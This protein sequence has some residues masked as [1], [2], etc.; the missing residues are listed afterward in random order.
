M[1]IT[2]ANCEKVV[3]AETLQKARALLFENKVIS[4]TNVEVNEHIGSLYEGVIKVG[5]KTYTLCFAIAING[6]IALDDCFCSFHTGSICKHYLAI[7]L[8]M[9]YR[10]NI[11]I[12]KRVFNPVRVILASSDSSPECVD[13]TVDSVFNRYI[14][15]NK[16][17]KWYMSCAIEGLVFAF[18]CAEAQEKSFLERTALYAVAFSKV[19]RLFSLSAEKHSRILISHAKTL[20]KLV[21]SYL[22]SKLP[23]TSL[24]DTKTA[25]FKFYETSKTIRNWMVKYNVLGILT[26]F[27]HTPSLRIFLERNFKKKI[28]NQKNVDKK[29]DLRVLY[30]MVLRAYS[31]KLASSYI[32]KNLDDASFR[33]MAIDLN[34]ANGEF[35]EAK[36]LAKEGL[37]YDK[38]NKKNTVM[39]TETMYD[40][41]AYLDDKKSM[42]TYAKKLLLL[43]DFDYFGKYKKM[44][45]QDEWQNEREKLIASLKASK[46]HS[47]IYLQIIIEENIQ[48]ELVAFCQDNPDKIAN[49]YPYI[50]TEYYKDIQSHLENYCKKLVSQSVG[51]EE[52]KFQKIALTKLKRK[53]AR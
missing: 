18:M 36:R 53:T 48:K 1:K 25:F 38:G 43:G 7:F 8:Y 50:K 4:V 23:N 46:K 51:K 39:W 27:C 45:D 20:V 19:D 35:A 49:Y 26:Q 47:E 13:K 37:E 10:K 11:T 40:I 42:K 41:S 44:F 22:S 28:Y 12:D 16:I 5:R 31:I 24:N 14:V 32:E 30:C 29:S 21:N 15:K 2:I 33:R 3:D 34:I 52:I 9:K 6:L 17:S